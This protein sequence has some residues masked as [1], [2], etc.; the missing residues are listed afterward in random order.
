MPAGPINNGV[1]YDYIRLELD[2]PQAAQAKLA[3]INTEP[4]NSEAA[5]AVAPSTIFIAGDS[6]A[7]NGVPDAIG[8]GKHLGAFF[9]PA[10]I[11]VVE[12]WLAAAGA[13][14]R[15]SRKDIG[16]ACWRM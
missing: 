1:I 5:V 15:S 4:A 16:T 3:P 12:S 7:A 10:K 14:A 2:D 6:T 13:A 8:W 11:K 9:D